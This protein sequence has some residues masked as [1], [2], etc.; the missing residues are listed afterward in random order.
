MELL[1]VQAVA[2]GVEIG[3]VP[4]ALE[5]YPGFST[6]GG[7]IAINRLHDETHPGTVGEGRALVGLENAVFEGGCE[8]LNHVG[9]IAD[10]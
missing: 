8:D 2:C 10:G 5:G 7:F 4:E 6:A 1:A 3:G 9:I